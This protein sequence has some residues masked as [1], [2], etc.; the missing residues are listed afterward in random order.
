MHNV[1]MISMKPSAPCTQVAS[2]TDFQSQL[3]HRYKTLSSQDSGLHPI[4][5][6]ISESKGK[7]IRS[8]LIFY[9]AQLLGD[10]QPEHETVACVIEY[11]HWASLLHD[12]VL[13]QGQMRRQKPWMHT[14]YG[15]TLAILGG[16]WYV[17]Q[18][19][20]LLLTL[21]DRSVIETVQGVM[22]PLI[23]GQ[24][25]DCA[26]QPDMTQDEYLTMIGC[27]TAAL[28]S[29]A[30]QASAMISGAK[31][32]S[33]HALTHYAYAM[34]LAYQLKDDAVEYAAPPEVWD[35]GHDFC[36]NKVTL[37]W[38]FAKK[39]L[40]SEEWA[41]LLSIQE[42][43]CTQKING[44]HGMTLSEA[45]PLLHRVHRLFQGGVQYTRHLAQG[46]KDQG[47]ASLL[48]CW[49]MDC[50]QNLWHWASF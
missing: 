15:N 40:S 37:P 11:L 46:Y 29:V 3:H 36:Q 26:V 6:S 19:I 14:L 49:P 23:Q 13:D 20:S 50:V 47:L 43:I 32:D 5:G 4:I 44:E 2:W 17:A 21:Q 30:A 45:R 35:F 42:R 18:S 38:I 33:V 41:E 25:M 48:D 22:R 27:K 1:F 12:G 24:M 8:Q 34:G 31:D 10:V 28:F 7:E 16:D 9:V 39:T